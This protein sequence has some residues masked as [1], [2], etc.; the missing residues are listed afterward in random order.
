M[1]QETL[2]KTDTVTS[3]VPEDEY[4][5]LRFTFI[6]SSAYRL[7]DGL[8]KDQLASCFMSDQSKDC[9]KLLGY[10]VIVSCCKPVHVEL[11]EDGQDNVKNGSVSWT[12]NNLI[13]YM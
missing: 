13:F 12:K 4:N 7:L 3:E 2:K 1:F 6:W 10:N 8:M 5:R 9:A 11:F